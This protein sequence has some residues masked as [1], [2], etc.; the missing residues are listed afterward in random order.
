MVCGVVNGGL[1][2]KLAANSHN[3]IVAYGVMAGAL[4][5]LYIA[6]MVFRV[7]R[8]QSSVAERGRRRTGL[9]TSRRK[10]EREADAS[11]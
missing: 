1:G 11:S 7:G 3:G 2:L 4:G 9:R 10:E 5:V 6:I 8:R